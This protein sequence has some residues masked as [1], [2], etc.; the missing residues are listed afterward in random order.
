MK[1][2]LPGEFSGKSVYK[3]FSEAY[4]IPKFDSYEWE[5]EVTRTRNYGRLNDEGVTELGQTI[6]P[7][8]FLGQ[9][10]G[11][12]PGVTDLLYDTDRSFEIELVSLRF[13]EKYREITV[14]VIMHLAEIG[15]SVA[16]E[17]PFLDLK[18]CQERVTYIFEKFEIFLKRF[19]QELSKDE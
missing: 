12:W 18:K 13:N 7:T 19:F 4:F 6:R 16:W 11:R 1:I 9:R 10:A 14:N 3:A 5:Q 8:R 15:R 17:E 2:K